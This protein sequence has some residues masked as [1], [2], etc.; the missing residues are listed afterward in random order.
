MSQALE[1]YVSFQSQHRHSTESKLTLVVPDR[2]DS[3]LWN[4][5]VD[6][7]LISLPDQLLAMVVVA[8]GI[9]CALQTV[10]F[11]AKHVVAMAAVAGSMLN[12]STI[13]LTECRNRGVLPISHTEHKWLA[14]IFRPQS[15][16]IEFV[17]SEDDFEHQ[18]W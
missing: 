4:L 2:F 10:A 11:P 6:S 5:T 12:I 18:L 3:R 9:Q 17:S 14:A 13:P 16:A 8:A 7:L 15:I 1:L